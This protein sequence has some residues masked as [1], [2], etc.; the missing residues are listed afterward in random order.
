M[1]LI[2]LSNLFS[3]LSNTTRMHS[4][5]MRTARSSSRQAE[6]LPQCMMGSPPVWAWRPPRCGPGDPSPARPLKLLL[7]CGPGKVQGMLGY[8]LPPGDL[9]GMLGYPPWT[10]RYV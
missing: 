3:K 2:T 8:T 9:Q 10:D 5:R 4:S 6:G 7:G 1:R